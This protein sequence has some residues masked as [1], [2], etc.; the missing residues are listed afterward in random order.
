MIT[1]EAAVWQHRLLHRLS[2]P[3]LVSPVL[4]RLLQESTTP[5]RELRPWFLLI[6]LR[7]ASLSWTLLQTTP[8]AG[9]LRLVESCPV[10]PSSQVLR[11]TAACGP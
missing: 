9:V 8:T 2:P 10:S 7:V 5:R 6:R 1:T 11:R 4:R 3:P